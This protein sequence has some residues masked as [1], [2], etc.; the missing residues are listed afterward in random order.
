[1][2]LVIQNAFMTNKPVNPVE[3]ECES[4]SCLDAAEKVLDECANQSSMHYKDIARIAREK[5]WL[6]SNA[7]DPAHSLHSSIW[8]DTRKK[9]PSRFV[10]DDQTG[11]ISLTKWGAA[12]FIIKVENHNKKQ[13]KDLLALLRGMDPGKFESFVAA[14]VL[15]AMGFEECAATQRSHDRGIDAVGQLVI[16]NSVRV[17]VAVQIKRYKETKVSC[18]T[19]RDLR[20]SLKPGQ[21]GV[22]ITT[23]EYSRD[24]RKEAEDIDGEK[25]RISLLDGK[26]IVELLVDMDWE[27]REGDEKGIE[28]KRLTM[29]QVNKKFFTEFGNTPNTENISPT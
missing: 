15:P 23:S 5:G 20:G 21:Q 25:A 4:Y 9:A 24:A 3:M 22:I 14:V 26:D 19:V 2:G 13:R 16:H 12:P 6:V 28:V 7:K 29:I 8:K 18:R 1:M 10:M 11:M 27:N 17:N